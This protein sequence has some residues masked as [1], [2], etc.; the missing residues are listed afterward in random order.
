[1]LAIFL[2]NT[3]GAMTQTVHA[4]EVLEADVVIYGGTSAGVAAAVQCKRMGKSTLIIE[5]SAHLGGLTTGG[6]GWTDSGNKSVIGGI[7]LEFYERVKKEY[8][9]E[10]TWK[11]QE[12]EKYSRYNPEAEAIWVFEPH[13]AEKVFND[14]IVEYEIPVYMNER[15]ELK[16]GVTTKE[17]QIV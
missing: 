9:K 3:T 5:P 13:I 15:L 10:E 11:W 6:L 2:L 4:D 8:D 14:L 1:M 12:S 16:E 7:S 17:G